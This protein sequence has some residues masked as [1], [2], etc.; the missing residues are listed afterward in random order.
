M[1]EFILEPEWSFQSV[2]IDP[3]GVRADV[4]ITVPAAKAGP[5]VREMA[6]IAQMMAGGVF[7]HILRSD[8]QAVVHAHTGAES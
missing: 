4:T 3:S 7:G 8:S 1:S 5:D 6:E 2:I